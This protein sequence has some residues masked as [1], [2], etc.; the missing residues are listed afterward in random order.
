MGV[1]V[2]AVTL[3]ASLTANI[4]LFFKLRKQINELKKVEEELRKVEK[5]LE[6]YRSAP[7]QY[8]ETYRDWVIVKIRDRFHRLEWIYVAYKK[9]HVILG[10]DLPDLIADIDEAEKK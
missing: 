5:E 8:V 9:E 6:G 3:V 10:V 4:Y 2:L 1:V 7:V